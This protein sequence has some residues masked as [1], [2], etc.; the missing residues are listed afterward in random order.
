MRPLV[1]PKQGVV[2]RWRAVVDDCWTF[3]RLRSLELRMF[4]LKCRMCLCEFRMLKFERRM[5]GLRG[6][7]LITGGVHKGMKCPCAGDSG[8]INP[9][10][11]VI[12]VFC[13]GHV[14]IRGWGIKCLGAHSVDS[15]SSVPD[16]NKTSPTPRTGEV[17]HQTEGCP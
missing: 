10:V 1:I 17:A 16:E 12:E 9:I 5:L 13:R 2:V 11:Q 7:D 15:L 14:M 3:Y 6:L 4:I 8:H